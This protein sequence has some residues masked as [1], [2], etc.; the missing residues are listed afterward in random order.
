M[1]RT[2]GSV[3]VL[4]ASGDE[5]LASVN[6]ALSQASPELH[7]VMVDTFNGPALCAPAA[8]ILIAPCCRNNLSKALCDTRYFVK[9]R[10]RALSSDNP[11][12]SGRHFDLEVRVSKPASQPRPHPWSLITHTIKA[13]S[14]GSLFAGT[15]VAA[16]F[17]SSCCTTSC[18]WAFLLPL[19]LLLLLLRV[20]AAS[21]L[22]GCSPPTSSW[23]RC[24]YPPSEMFARVRRVCECVA[25]PWAG[26]ACPPLAMR[27][28]PWGGV[29]SRVVSTF[30]DA[31]RASL[32]NKVGGVFGGCSTGRCAAA[33]LWL[34]RSAVHLFLFF[35]FLLLFSASLSSFASLSTC[36]AE[37]VR[38][39]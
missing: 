22:L 33:L 21:Y 9:R 6:T 34:L 36:R 18:P 31:T 29:K 35:F 8:E 10:G 19:L 3:L 23:S 13:Q 14:A 5:T 1:T 27:R 4:S 32:V 24:L 30:G 12:G 26:T 39:V 2:F 28:W 7:H 11:L 15:L 25:S 38:G 17:A 16:G 20:R 37:P